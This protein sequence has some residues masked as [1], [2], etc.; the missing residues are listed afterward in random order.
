LKWRPIRL[1]H[2]SRDYLFLPPKLEKGEVWDGRD[3]SCP[4][5]DIIIDTGTP[6]TIIP[7]TAA[8]LLGVKIATV[9]NIDLVLPDNTILSCPS[10]YVKV[11]HEDF[12]SIGPIKAAFMHR[13]NIL[14]GRDCLSHL[15]LAYDGK[16][17]RFLIRKRRKVDGILLACLGFRKHS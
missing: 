2:L 14:L 6:R 12:G 4:G 1:N 10:L 17:A 15:L 7:L 8:A 16:N 9:P 3:Y 5:W 11:F 13:D